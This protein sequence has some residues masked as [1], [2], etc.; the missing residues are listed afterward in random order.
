[1][2]T[3]RLLLTENVDNLGIVGEVVQV[4]TGYARNY[5]I[6]R[7]LATSPTEGAIKRLA[8]RRAQVEQERRERRT[9]RRTNVGED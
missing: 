2:K 3:S 1:M 4:K 5:L 6:P 8:E 9:S 7:G